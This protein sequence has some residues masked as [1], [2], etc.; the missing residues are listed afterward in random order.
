MPYSQFGAGIGLTE[1]ESLYSL[2]PKQGCI[3]NGT[4]SG[5][6]IAQLVMDCTSSNLEVF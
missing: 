5:K 2:L 6:L 4:L 1:A 3:A